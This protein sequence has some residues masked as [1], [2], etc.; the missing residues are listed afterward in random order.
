VSNKKN[1]FYFIKPC[2]LNVKVQVR[3]PENYLP[4]ESIYVGHECN[5]LLKQI[6]DEA[7]KHKIRLNCLAF[8]IVA[9]EEL[10]L[11][12][13]TEENSIFKDFEVLNPIV[14]LGKDRSTINFTDLCV[15]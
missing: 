8:Y 5:N 6:P 9:L 4:L 10:Q 14:A 2:K 11:R 7:E 1:I 13:P 12:L 3:A 15:R